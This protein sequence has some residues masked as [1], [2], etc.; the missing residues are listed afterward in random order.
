MELERKI[1]EFA[2]KM[3]KEARDF[4]LSAKNRVSNPNTKLLI[5]YLADWE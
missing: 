3:E 1:L 4:Y 5:D 2:L